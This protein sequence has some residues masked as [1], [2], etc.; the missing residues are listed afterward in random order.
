MGTGFCIFLNRSCWAIRSEIARWTE[1]LG[2]HVGSLVVKTKKPKEIDMSNLKSAVQKLSGRMQKT[3]LVAM[4]VVMLVLPAGPVA[5]N[6][7]HPCGAGCQTITAR[8]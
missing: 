2:A 4:V 3:L 7:G 5:A 1:R 8:R 6:E